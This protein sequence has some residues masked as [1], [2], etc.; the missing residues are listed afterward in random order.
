MGVKN[1]WSLNVGEALVA[2]K[3]QN[4]LGKDYTVF[5][6]IKANLKDIDLVLMN[7]VEGSTKT[8]QVKSSRAH[9]PLKHEVRRHGEGSSGWIQISKK[10][11]SE[12]TYKIDYFILVAHSM[13]YDGSRKKIDVHYFII[14]SSELK[15]LVSN[16]KLL[17]SGKYDFFLWMDKQGERY[18]DFNTKDKLKTIDLKPYLEDWESLI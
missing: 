3:I 8:I 5:F 7:L 4:K 14:P 12:S 1:F 9:A 18:F 16:K 6:P 17:K 15:S 10:C 11:I 2:D 13:S